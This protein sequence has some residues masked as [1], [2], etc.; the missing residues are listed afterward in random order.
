VCLIENSLQEAEPTFVTAC[1]VFM[2]IFASPK[3]GSASPTLVALAN[4]LEAH[5]VTPVTVLL[6][7]QVSLGSS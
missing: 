1:L 3:P 7:S 2:V 6:S 5:T 4:V